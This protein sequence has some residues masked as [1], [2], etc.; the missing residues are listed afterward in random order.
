MRVAEEKRERACSKTANAIK[1][2]W[3]E[4]KEGEEGAVSALYGRLGKD[5]HKM[6]ALWRATFHHFAIEFQRLL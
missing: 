3:G 4:R 1:N 2:V 6:P 5:P